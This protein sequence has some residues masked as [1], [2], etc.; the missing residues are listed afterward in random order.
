[1]VFILLENKSGPNWSKEVLRFEIYPHSMDEVIAAGQ[2]AGLSLVSI[3][4]GFSD[5]KPDAPNSSD[6]LYEFIKT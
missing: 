2:D 1:V 3:Q 4:G 5:E 6:L